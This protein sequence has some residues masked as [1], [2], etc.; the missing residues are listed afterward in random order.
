MTRY[1]VKMYDQES[2]QWFAYG[3]YESRNQANEVALMVRD[4]RGVWVTVEEVEG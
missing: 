2:E 3:T 1:Q 4:S